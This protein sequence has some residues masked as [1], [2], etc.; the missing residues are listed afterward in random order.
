MSYLNKLNESLQNPE[1]VKERTLSFNEKVSERKS[2][3]TEPVITVN[4]ETGRMTITFFID[5]I[6]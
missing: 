2:T 6:N 5:P 3:S 1:S 4:K